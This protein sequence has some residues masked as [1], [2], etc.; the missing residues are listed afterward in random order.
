MAVAAVTIPTALIGLVAAG[1]ADA[2]T[3]Q[4]PGGVAAPTAAEVSPICDAPNPSGSLGPAVSLPANPTST[5]V[6]PPGGV[7]NFTATSTNLYVLTSSQLIT[8][9]LSGSQVGSF[10]LPSGFSGGSCDL[11]TGRRPGGE[12]LSVQLSQWGARR[13]QRRW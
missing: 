7:V 3:P 2:P 13:I 9:T 11:P 10:S 1:N 6:A 8:Y 12:H 4:I 5:V